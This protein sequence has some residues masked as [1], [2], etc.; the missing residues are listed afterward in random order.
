[1]V[2]L[3]S[4]YGLKAI[5][6]LADAYGKGHVQAKQI[7]A[8]QDIPVRYLELLLSQL[9]RS[10]MV[11][12][13]RGKNGGYVLAKKP[14]KITVWDIVMIFEGKVIFAQTESPMGNKKTPAAYINVWKEAEKK[15]VDY[16]KSIKI[17][18]LLEAV[19]SGR[20]TYV[21]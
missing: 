15:M 11:N 4:H 20:K 21:M 19:K 16:L 3:K 10:R 18:K 9:R 14:D 13:I 2:S 6:A 1:M 7:A 12:A 5:V 17:S 8:R